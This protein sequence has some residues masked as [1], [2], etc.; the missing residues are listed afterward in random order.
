MRHSG[1]SSRARAGPAMA[2]RDRKPELVTSRAMLRAVVLAWGLEATDSG[3]L[4][5]PRCQS[6]VGHM[7]HVPCRL[8]LPWPEVHD[9]PERQRL[10]V[11][12]VEYTESVLESQQILV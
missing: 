12:G 5:V 6:N 7:Q 4:V 1:R 9:I 3:I 10:H 8:D 2:K 11:I